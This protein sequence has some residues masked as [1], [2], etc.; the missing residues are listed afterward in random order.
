MPADENRPKQEVNEE[1][2]ILGTHMAG[3]TDL[4]QTRKAPENSQIDPPPHPGGTG[5]GSAT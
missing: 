2:S 5:T 4:F 1:L 3:A